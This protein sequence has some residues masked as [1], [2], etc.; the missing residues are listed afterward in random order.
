MRL[1]E[2]K[3]AK[4]I[5]HKIMVEN[6]MVERW[7]MARIKAAQ[8]QLDLAKFRRKVEDNDR[9]VKTAISPQAAMAAA[10]AGETLREELL[11]LEAEVDEQAVCAFEEKLVVRG[12]PRREP[13]SWRS[14][15]MLPHLRARRTTLSSPAH[16]QNF[17]YSPVSLHLCAGGGQ[18]TRRPARGRGCTDKVGAASAA[19]QEGPPR[20]PSIGSVRVYDDHVRH[21]EGE[22]SGHRAGT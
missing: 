5:C 2:E 12:C 9:A 3:E 20:I 10:R 15:S 8:L 14:W 16:S 22:C 21:Q 4:A 17:A 7:E 13:Q 11:Q 1:S 19:H 18:G 6:K